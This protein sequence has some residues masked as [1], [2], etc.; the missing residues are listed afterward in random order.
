[1]SECLMRVVFNRW[2]VFLWL[3]LCGTDGILHLC[4]WLWSCWRWA[5]PVLHICRWAH[6][7]LHMSRP[8]RWFT[9]LFCHNRHVQTHLLLFDGDESVHTVSCPAALSVPS[10]VL[11]HNSSLNISIATR[12]KISDGVNESADAHVRQ[13]FA[14]S[15][16]SHAG[17]AWSEIISSLHQAG[18][19][20]RFVKRLEAPQ[21][22][23]LFR[24]Q[25]MWECFFNF[26]FTSDDGNN[27]C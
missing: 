1:M 17:Y 26:F 5:W 4:F 23:N 21:H 6:T 2:E 14:V 20:A 15:Q 27:K 9:L 25:F 8:R 19:S 11:E 18:F 7:H 24:V 12:E 13:M 3:N 22:H 10:R 16:C